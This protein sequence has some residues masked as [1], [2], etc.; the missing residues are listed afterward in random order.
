MRRRTIL[1]SGVAVAAGAI[2]A[3][4]L[5]QSGKWPAREIT[6]INPNAAGASTDLTARILAQALE[7]RLGATVIV[8]NVVGGAGAL[9]PTTLAQSAPDGHTF[10]LVAISSHVA[11]PNMMNVTYDPW[12]AF[13]VLGQVAEMTSPGVAVFRL[14][15][16]ELRLTPVLES[17]DARDL[18][19]IFRDATS[20][21]ETYGAGRYLEPQELP[22]G[23]I[24]LDFN[25]AYNPF[26][27]YS[28]S[29][30][31]PLPPFE[32]HLTVAIRAGEKDF[33]K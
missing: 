2:A 10:G 17:P 28:S 11:V 31:C 26:C 16:R 13:D 24:L 30:S 18:F 15:G 1:K 22:N 23:Q 8:K 9:G 6:L 20:G 12:K 3:P 7:K 19:F 25:L 32:N 14:A 4:A 21:R 33:K 5:A 29:Y 27:A